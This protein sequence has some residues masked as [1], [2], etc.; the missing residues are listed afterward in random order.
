MYNKPLAVI[1]DCFSGCGGNSVALASTCKD[2]HVVSV[3]IDPEKAHSCRHNALVYGVADRI[4]IICADVYDV[5]STMETTALAPSTAVDPG[6]GG[7]TGGVVKKAEA[8]QVDVVD[9]LP[10][11]SRD[12]G[13]HLTASK[14]IYASTQ[15]AHQLSDATVLASVLD[16]I[17]M[18]PPWGGPE[19]SAVARYDLRTMI[20]SGDL[21]ELTAKALRVCSNVVLIV[22]RN[23]HK[24]HIED[25]TRELGTCAVVEDMYMGPKVKM[26][27]I[28][29]GPMFRS[30]SATKK[31]K[32]GRVSG[33]ARHAVADI[34]SASI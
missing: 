28:Y 34:V 27:V 26:S 22:P 30:K 24:D 18:S 6:G 11:T 29:L 16:V 17:V 25:L 14:A 15:C 8:S 21:F 10:D 31:A 3:E 20:P 32:S 12:S 13:D 23:T 19:Y 5:L 7:M 2:I 9:M 4:D 33:M 1:L